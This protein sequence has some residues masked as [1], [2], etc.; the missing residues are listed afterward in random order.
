V[1]TQQIYALLLDIKESLPTRVDTRWTHFQEP[2]A[3]EDAHGRVFPVPS[4]YDF[5]LLNTIVSHRFSSGPRVREVNPRPYRLLPANNT[6]VALTQTDQLLPGMR[7]KVAVIVGV[8]N[9][10]Y[11]MNYCIRKGCHSTR[12]TRPRGGGVTW[13]V[14]S[15]LQRILPL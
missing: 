11:D 14:F 9:M 3:V 7:V 10:L 1:Y 6:K 2:L 12:L 15:P 4:E 13:C 5:D 8:I